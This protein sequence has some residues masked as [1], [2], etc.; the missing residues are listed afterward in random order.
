MAKHL[1]NPV[2]HKMNEQEW[3]DVL[4]ITFAS[5]RRTGGEQSVSLLRIIEKEVEIGNLK[6]LDKK[7]DITRIREIIY[8]LNGEGGENVQR[9]WIKSNSST[10]EEEQMLRKGFIGLA[11]DDNDVYNFKQMLNGFGGIDSATRLQNWLISIEKLKYLIMEQIVNIQTS[12]DCKEN[13][14][15]ELIQQSKKNDEK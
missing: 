3:Q 8:L 13:E 15:K 2:G 7:L 6:K 14:V 12:L 1:S 10:P 5:Q 11:R 4:D 9:N